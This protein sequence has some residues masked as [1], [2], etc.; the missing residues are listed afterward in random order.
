MF[1]YID[2]IQ[3][4]AVRGRST[5]TFTRALEWHVVT[6]ETILQKRL[7][8]LLCNIPHCL[9][10]LISFWISVG[11]RWCGGRRRRVFAVCRTRWWWWCFVTNVAAAVASVCWL[12]NCGLF[13][14]LLILLQVRST[15]II[16][17][18]QVRIAVCYCTIILWISW[19]FCWFVVLLLLLLVGFFFF[20]A[21]DTCANLESCLVTHCPFRFARS[22]S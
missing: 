15:V 5:L 22:R 19:V 7:W 20:F 1:L 21:N 2:L 3:T 4:V 14:V 13:G 18:L 16:K 9:S 11:S 12:S 6:I 17:S 10:A 8:W